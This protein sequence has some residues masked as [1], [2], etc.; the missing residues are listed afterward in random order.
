M[1]ETLK[2]LN[3][4]SFYQNALTTAVVSM[5]VCVIANFFSRDSYYRTRIL[6][7]T[8]VAIIFGFWI[9]PFGYN[10]IFPSDTLLFSSDQLFQLAKYNVVCSIIGALIGYGGSEYV[11]DN[12]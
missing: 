6:F 3:D 4:S 2:L 10:A 11:H 8:A 9:I 7:G 12:Y 5:A 1:W